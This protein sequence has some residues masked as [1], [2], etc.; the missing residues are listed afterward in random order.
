MS[1]EPF[2]LT[3]MFNAVAGTP[4]QYDDAPEGET[5]SA[6]GAQQ[7]QEVPEEVLQDSYDEPDPSPEAARMDRIEAVLER[8]SGV[9]LQAQPTAQAATQQLLSEQ[10]PQEPS[11]ATQ[12]AHPKDGYVTREE[13]D[14]LGVDASA[15]NALLSRAA[16]H[17][18]QQAFELGRQALRV[19][20]PQIVARSFKE[21]Q[22]AEQINAEFWS[23]N[24]DLWASAK[25]PEEQQA[26]LTALQ[27]AVTLA[28]QRD[29]S[30]S[31]KAA[32]KRA[33][34]AV[35]L[36]RG[37]PKAGKAAPTRKTHPATGVFPQARTQ[38]APRQS[39]TTQT[40]P[41][42]EMTNVIRAAFGNR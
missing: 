33:G 40:I 16:L 17:A 38:A 22:T 20:A 4:P 5:L 28:V 2:D 14:A 10:P 32:F 3:A 39:A 6:Q 8:L 29:P 25:Q 11:F 42:A 13:A 26:L 19:E 15:L 24:K 18:A 34:D 37:I 41:D 12:F 31:V 30:L 9:L 35:R 7:G 23:E 1:N 36:V 27:G 21:R